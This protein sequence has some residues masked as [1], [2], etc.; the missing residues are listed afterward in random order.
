[1][2]FRQHHQHAEC[3]ECWSRRQELASKNLS[4]QER[5]VIATKWRK[6]LALQYADRILYWTIRYGSRAK[7]NILSI[8]ADAMDKSKMAY[9]KYPYHRVPHEL[10]NMARPRMVLTAVLAHGHRVGV[11]LSDDET[12]T[13]GSDHLIEILCRVIQSIAVH[14]HLPS[15]LCLQS[16]NTTSFS[17]NANTHLFMAWLVAS[18]RF[19]TVT[20]NYLT[21]GHTHEDVD[22]FFAEL[23]PILRRHDFQCLDDILAFLETELKPRAEQSG[24]EL[25]LQDSSSVHAFGDWLSNMG[26]HLHNAFL[27]RRPAGENE[28]RPV[29]HSYVYKRRMDLTALETSRL[30]RQEAQGAVGDVFAVVKSRML[31]GADQAHA[32]VLVLPADR[33]ARLPSFENISLCERVCPSPQRRKML[34]KLAAT[35]CDPPYNRGAAADALRKLGA[36][37]FQNCESDLSW[38]NQLGLPQHPA[39]VVSGGREFPHLP[40]VVWPLRARFN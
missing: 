19:A 9:P 18:S 12:V 24:Q 11:F 39:L 5:I 16:D 13:H 26:V 7:L 40:D 2:Q 20:V 29:P 15:H 14:G 25:V 34:E 6:H 30:A 23:L 38:F 3:S 37:N 17:K 1:M 28:L 4:A 10:E 27:A 32:P 33:L 8:V 35:L 22:A 21:R 36:G 31:D